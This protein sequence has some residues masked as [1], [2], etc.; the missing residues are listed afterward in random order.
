MA[1]RIVKGPFSIKW[2]ENPILDVTDLTFN[3]DVATNDYETIQGTTYTVDGAITAS[4]ELTLLKSDVEALRTIF[5]LYFVEKGQTLSTGE[6]ATED[7]IDITAAACDTVDTQYNLD[8]TS[9]A[10][11]ITR[12]VNAKAS[13]SGMEIADNSIRTVTVTFRGEPKVVDG[14]TSALI[15]FIDAASES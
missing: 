8:I 2:G 11:D 1:S 4:V 9:C 5:P 13:L 7:T 12:L 15:Q 14:K 6:V 3:Y 10:G